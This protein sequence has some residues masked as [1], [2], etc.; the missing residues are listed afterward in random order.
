MNHPASPSRRNFLKSAGSALV[1][2][3]FLPTLSRFGDAEAA[4]NTQV[5]TWLAVGSDDS[6]NTKK[7][8]KV[9]HAKKQQRIRNLFLCCG[10]LF[11]HR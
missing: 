5:N 6:I 9:A 1:L 10:K 8:E 11:H 7:L 3:L 4:T 2:G